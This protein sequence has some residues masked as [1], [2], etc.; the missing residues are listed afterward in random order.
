MKRRTYSIGTDIGGTFTDCTVLTSDGQIVTGKSPSTPPNF[1][2]GFFGAVEDAAGTLG[3]SL[4][5][6]LSQATTLVHATTAATNA[7]VQ[8]KGAKVGLITT[9][10]H[11]DAMLVMRGGGRSKGLD[12]DDLLYLPGMTKPDPIV[13]PELIREV[14]ERVDCKGE[15]VVGLVEEQARTAIEELVEA[16]AETIAVAFLWSFLHPE[17]ECRVR[18]LIEE[19]APDLFVSCSHDIA[20][21]VG[22]YY[23]TVATVMNSYVGPLMNDY[24]GQIADG[25]REQGYERPVLFAQCIGG[26]V[27]VSEVKRR[28]LFTLDSGPV[29]GIVAS[30]YLG[31]QFGFQNIITADMGGTTFDVAVID[32]NAPLTR[33]STN[34]DRYEMYLPMLDVESIGAGGG[35][36][37]WID[38]ASGTMK[39]GPQ[40]AGADPGPVCYRN[41]GTEPTVTDANVV[42][43][44][45]N[46][47]RFLHGRRT[48]DRDAS[49]AAVSALGE[50]IGLDMEKTAAGIIEIVDNLMAE[51]IR[52]MTVYR[53]HDPREF[54]VFSFGGAAGAHASSFS[55][56]LGVSAVVVPVGNIASVLSALGTISGDVMHV[57]DRAARLPAPFDLEEINAGFARLEEQAFDQLGAEGFDRRDVSLAR[58]V[59]MKYGAQVFDVEVPFDAG[60][61][62]DDLVARFEGTYERRFGKDSGYAP[63]GIELIRLRMYASGS[64]PRPELAATLSG[65]G[66]RQRETRSVYWR[67]LGEYVE[68]PIY[69][70]VTGA[71]D[72]PAVIELPDTTVVVRP[73]DRLR[74]DAHQNL[75]LTFD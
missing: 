42:L 53:G 7:L 5:D 23:R 65:D 9:R 35:S 32:G 24:V 56:S 64:L 69:E 27:P 1:S 41:G 57:Y 3:L 52:R 31:E 21:R 48:L 34:L 2:E 55:R 67:E 15:V 44:V 63:A 6:L 75:V 51:K 12:V 61:S 74:S 18:D 60:D 29:S 37:A 25:A 13:A 22:E 33:E 49:C 30:N 50:R 36:I 20:P 45:I 66:R 17:H 26:T 28:P 39:V 8:R 46:P 59:S 4:P 40:S 16:G 72:G 58:L 68:T 38:P 19:I 47:E 11:G 10:G 43:G 73:G 62:G 70:E 14:S 71:I 54:A